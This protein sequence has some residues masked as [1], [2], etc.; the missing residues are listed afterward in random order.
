MLSPSPAP[1]KLPG[2]RWPWLLAGALA[3]VTGAV[4]VL[5]AWAPGWARERAHSALQ[6]RLSE[7]LDEP[8]EIGEVVLGWGRA[9]IHDVRVGDP[10]APVVRLDHVIVHLDEEALWRGYVV[11]TA[12]EIE[13]GR[14]EGSR[15]RLEALARAALRRRERDPE[16]TPGRI[17]PIPDLIELRDIDV[18]IDD[19]ARSASGRLRMTVRPRERA[20]DVALREVR[21]TWGKR[22]I[23]AA[24]VQTAFSVRGGRPPVPLRIEIEGLG[25]RITPKI[26]VAGVAG[27]VTLHDA[28][29][30]DISIDLDGGFSDREDA[31]AAAKLWSVVGRVRRDIGR[32]RLTLDMEA[33]ELMR[34]P[35]VLRS[36]PLVDSETATIGGRVAV[37]LGAGVVRVDG[38]IAIDGLNVRHPTLARHTVHDVGFD[39]RVNAE[40]EPAA[41]RVRIPFAL[42]Q[43]EGVELR[44]SAEL[45]HPRDRTGRHYH[46]EIDMPPRPC[47]RVLD[48][49]PPELVPALRGFRLEG[50]LR[51]WTRVDVD[52]AELENLVLDGDVAAWDCKVVEPPPDADAARLAGSF[53]HR[54]TM[55]DGRVRTV[56]VGY[57]SPSFTPYEEISPYMVAAVLTTEDG[58]FF[59]HR[60]FLPSQ[61][62]TA[63]ERNLR[64]GKV[65]LGAS[66]ISMQM[67]KNVWL[68]HERTLSRKLQEMFLT[69]YAETALS[70]Q[71]ILEIYLNVVELGPGIYGVTRAADHYFGKSPGELTPPEAAYLALMLPSPVR[72][73]VHYCNGQP[74][75]A[76]KIK[77]QRILAIMHGRGRIDALDYEVYKEGEIVFDLRDRGDSGACRAE[78]DALMAAN[79]GQRALSGLLPP[80]EDMEIIEE[81]EPEPEIGF[82]D[83]L[84]LPSVLDGETTGVAGEGANGSRRRDTTADV[85]APGRPAMDPA[86]EGD[87]VDT[88]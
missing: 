27:T 3:L 58:G 51:G 11:A 60:G 85:D 73:H 79:E 46:V 23:V 48:A 70:K 9:D 53:T 65:R 82:E 1:T 50:D 7:R 30:D 19:G 2:P 43:R 22:D 36:L 67:I 14:I 61:F 35:E 31:D 75:D 10:D 62:K 33:F 16:R 29:L 5:V 80:P 83:D 4:V 38:E 17:R 40:I 81:P 21:A 47:Q 8:V 57:G 37:E 25:T 26:A 71:R 68:S 78:I 86:A 76:F 13:G 88:W 49:L 69:W 42:L 18:Q 39:L 87:E 56:Q 24:S 52:F 64:A 15:D 77:I 59:R 45:A 84:D 32:G 63:L 20:V 41:R 74:S 55:R 34:V 66:T 6:A 12:A 72:R 54:V 28:A 44:G